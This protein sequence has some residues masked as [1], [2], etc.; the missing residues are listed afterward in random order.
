[1]MGLTHD[2]INIL[3]SFKDSEVVK[4]IRK[5]IEAQEKQVIGALVNAEDEK[6][7]HKLRGE[8]RGLRSVLNII[9]SII[10]TQS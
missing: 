1:M 8:I 10:S 3:K 6:E 7:M 2:E 5:A 9:S 4:V